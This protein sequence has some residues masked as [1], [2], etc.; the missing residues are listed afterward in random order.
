MRAADCGKIGI[1]H[2][3]KTRYIKFLRGLASV[4]GAS[5]DGKRTLAAW[6]AISAASKGN[7]G[8]EIVNSSL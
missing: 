1:C 4:C 3:S 7:D 8:L 5:R 2:K 6:S